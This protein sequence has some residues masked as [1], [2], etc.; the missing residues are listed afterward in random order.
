MASQIRTFYQRSSGGRATWYEQ[1]VL[2]FTFSRVFVKFNRLV[3]LKKSFLRSSRDFEPIHTPTSVSNPSYPPKKV[4]FGENF[5]NMMT[6]GVM[7]D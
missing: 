5:V 1:A 6:K 3:S 7:S 4:K 2:I